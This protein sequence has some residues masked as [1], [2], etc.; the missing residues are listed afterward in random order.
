MSGQVRER[1][2]LIML[3]GPSAGEMLRTALMTMGYPAIVR[4]WSVHSIHH[5]PGAGVTVGYALTIDR[6]EPAG[7]QIRTEEYMCAST[8]R[9][10]QQDTPGLVHLTSQETGVWV[11]R[12]PGDPELPALRLACSPAEMTALLGE[13]VSVELMSYRP[14]R[15]AV[16]RVRG[17]TSVSYAKVARPPQVDSLAKRH[18]MLSVAGVCAPPVLMHDPRGLLVIGSAEGVPL[19][20]LISRGMGQMA[21]PMLTSLTGLLDSLPPQALSLS[22]RPAWADRS[23]HYA[24]AAATALPQ[25]RMRCE[26]LARGIVELLARSDPGP[27]VPVHGDFYEANIFVAAREPRVTGIIDVDSLGPGHRV[28]DWA[29]L[30]GH[31]SVLPHLAPQS[32]PHVGDDL[33][34]WRGVCETMVDP[35]ALCARTAGVVL[36]L[37]AGAKRVDGSEWRGDALGRLATAEAWLAR[38]YQHASAKPPF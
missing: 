35:V 6:I 23:K 9:I 32:Y 3:T 20:T 24:H 4:S 5:R 15:R 38:A 36:S 17:A 7:E 12:Y 28:D 14:T 10:S 31:M 13:P 33:P 30:L 21:L 34:V 2:D 1:E 8:A 29:C 22:H 11:W 37:V 27:L 26:A 16:V 25:Q 18:M 19:S